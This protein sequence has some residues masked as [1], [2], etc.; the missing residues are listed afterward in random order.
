M[1]IITLSPQER[2]IATQRTWEWQHLRQRK[3]RRTGEIVEDWQFYRNYTSLESALNDVADTWIRLA[4]QEDIL[5]A[6]QEVKNA[7]ARVCKALTHPLK[8]E[9]QDICNSVMENS[10]AKKSQ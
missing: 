4:K 6:T 3:H 7:L 10:D 1:P 2:L 5:V 8:D 9:V